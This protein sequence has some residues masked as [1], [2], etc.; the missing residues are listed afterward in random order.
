MR[1]Y[2]VCSGGTSDGSGSSRSVGYRTRTS[3]IPCTPSGSVSRSPMTSASLYGS[4]SVW[5]SRCAQ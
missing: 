3:N 2:A 5:Q 1:R 4:V